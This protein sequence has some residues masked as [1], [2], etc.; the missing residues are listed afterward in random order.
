MLF[1]L[2]VLES[3]ARDRTLV[4]EIASFAILASILAHGLTDT[5]GARCGR[6]APR[7]ERGVASVTALAA[8]GG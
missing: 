5:V 3:H 8:A 2:F 1:A 7:P 4:F 6:G